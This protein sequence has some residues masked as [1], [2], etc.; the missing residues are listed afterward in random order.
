MKNRVLRAI[1]ATFGF[2]AFV[3]TFIV[4]RGEHSQ[5]HLFLAY[6]AM[7]AELTTIVAAIFGLTNAA[8]IG[9][10]ATAVCLLGVHLSGGLNIR[11]WYKQSVFWILKVIQRGWDLRK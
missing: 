9:I 10:A 6:V 3:V 7:F 2:V 8:T 1:L 5:W 11:L 4:S